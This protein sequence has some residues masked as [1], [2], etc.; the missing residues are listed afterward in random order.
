MPLNTKEILTRLENEHRKVGRSREVR[1]VA[2]TVALRTNLH[3]QAVIHH[4]QQRPL[5]L[6]TVAKGKGRPSRPAFPCLC[7][8]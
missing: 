8:G 7:N 4:S 6:L 5:L 1:G 2:D 3:D